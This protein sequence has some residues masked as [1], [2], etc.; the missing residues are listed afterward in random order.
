MQ[1]GIEKVVVATYPAR[2]TKTGTP[3]GMVA[4]QDG[5][6]LGRFGGSVVTRDRR[7]R[8]TSVGVVLE[9]GIPR[10]FHA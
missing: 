6:F 2:C 1:S 9:Q 8:P 7:T 10:S 5:T 4:R 3:D